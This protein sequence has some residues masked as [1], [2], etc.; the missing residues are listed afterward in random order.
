MVMIELKKTSFDEL[1]SSP[2][3]QNTYLKYLFNDN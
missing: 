1:M 2:N 3:V